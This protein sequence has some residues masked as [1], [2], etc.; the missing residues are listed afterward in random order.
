MNKSFFEEIQTIL[1]E[2]QKKLEHEL[3]RFAHRNKKAV[4]DDYETDYQDYGDDEDENAREIATYSNN[5]SLENELE[6]ALRDVKRALERIEEGEYG[7]CKYCKTDI[8][9]ARLKAR[10]TASSCIA[11]KKTLTQEL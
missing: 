3:S 1:R 8:A 2:E 11:C 6:K 7:V 5:L 10:P 4:T 9:E